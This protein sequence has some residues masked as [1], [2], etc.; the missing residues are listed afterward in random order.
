MPATTSPRKI[1]LARCVANAPPYS[2]LKV[3]RPPNE[4]VRALRTAI[5]NSLASVKQNI[6]AP[7]HL[8]DQALETFYQA[9]VSNF[10][11]SILMRLRT[12]RYQ[13]LLS[14]IT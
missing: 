1:S 3:L 8:G 11:P 5:V 4:T 7:D 14:S 13:M 9:K 6:V 10:C 2:P 12:C